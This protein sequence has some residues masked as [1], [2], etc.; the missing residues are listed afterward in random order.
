MTFTGQASLT[1]T[2][3]FAYDLEDELVKLYRRENVT[4]MTVLPQYCYP[5]FIIGFNEKFEP[6]APP[7]EWKSHEWGEVK[8]L[9]DNKNIWFAVVA[10][11][12]NTII[13][14]T[15][16][17][18]GNLNAKIRHLKILGYRP[19]WVSFGRFGFI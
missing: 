10:A 18:L 7:N 17:P 5:D 1:G 9:P 16:E 14:N 8:K 6:Q 19:V 13:R 3:K 12:W 4:Y 15:E 11:G 2:Q